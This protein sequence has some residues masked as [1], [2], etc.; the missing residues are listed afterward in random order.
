MRPAPE[1]RAA[2]SEAIPDD[3]AWRQEWTRFLR[4]H[5]DEQ[6]LVDY[7]AIRDNP[8]ALE[9]LYAWVAEHSPESD[10]DLFPTRDARFAY[11]LNAYNIAAIRGIAAHYPV[12][13]VRD[14]KPFHVVSLIPGGG[15]FFAQ[16][17]VFGDDAKRLYFLE[18]RFMRKRFPDPR[19]H[20]ALNCG[21]MGC[22][23]LPREAFHP[24]RLDAQLERETRAFLAERRNLRI[25]S[26]AETVT[27]SAIFDWYRKDFLRPLRE[28][29]IEDPT[30]LDYVARHVDADTRRALQRAQDGGYAVAFADYSW[31]L[32]DQR[33][34]PR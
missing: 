16:K 17:F 21:S 11:W 4:K 9:R 8:A 13:S 34:G 5:V 27:L 20:F 26:E 23:Q 15:F 6:G 31:R 24:E 19:Q 25:D 18:R 28:A 30:L 1:D 12:D 2:A 22:P 33:F 14:I 32:N 29:G 7:A 3:D 10:P